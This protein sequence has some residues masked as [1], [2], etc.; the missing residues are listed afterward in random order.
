MFE[1][2][3]III[4]MAGSVIAA[5][6]D[7]LTT[8]VPDEL[9]A[10]M[11]SSGIGLW[12]FH[13]LSTGNYLPLFYS[14]V[15]GGAILILG[16]VL[17]QR[18]HWGGADAWLLAA[19]AFLLPLYSSEIFMYPFIFNLL[20]VGTVY[21]II[22]AIALGFKNRRVFKYFLEDIRENWRFVVPPIAVLGLLLLITYPYINYFI[23]TALILL[24]FFW[25]Y[26]LVIE[27][28]V[29]KKTIRSSE[30]K[31]GDVL[32]D[33]IWKGL[34]KKEVETIR[35]TK[36]FVTIKEG[37]RFI[38]VFPIALAITLFYG[39]LMFLFF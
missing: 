34:T 28:R 10:I 26:A 27:K 1:T 30:L 13:A 29:F 32:D 35:K 7:L 37:V 39:N 8:E 33:M 9:L 38:P 14:L 11:V 18:G 3:A 23:I 6:W 17:Y 15:I 31:E 21:M 2:I 19:T 20:I 22:Y 24:I 36:E 5:V 25:R 16:L 4:A 12:Y